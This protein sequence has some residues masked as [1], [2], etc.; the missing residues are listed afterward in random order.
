MNK[1]LLI[2]DN[3]EN[4]RSLN[5]LLTNAG[6]NTYLAEDVSNGVEIAKIYTPDLVLCDINNGG[7]G[8]KDVIRELAN[9]DR[10]KFIPLIYLSCKKDFDYIR[11]IMKAGADDF[12]PLPVKGAELIESIN[13]R[14][15]KYKL[16]KEHIDMVRKETI[17][18]TEDMPVREDHILVKIGTNLRIIKFEDILFVAA[19]REYTKVVTTDRN[20][21]IIR[22]SLKRWLDI[23]PGKSF[24]QI[25]RSTIINTNF[26]ASLKKLSMHSYEIFLENCDEPFAVS[27]RN[28]K[29]LKKWF[30]T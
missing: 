10:T 13:A 28:A 7:S 6:F 16:F 29:K 4:I 21:Y 20:K 30:Y 27:V 11:T 24:L 18:A 8:G 1:I 19:S 2:Y 9:H 14:L 12:L 5:V 17:E 23:L 22:K 26:I 25:H 3:N 15:K